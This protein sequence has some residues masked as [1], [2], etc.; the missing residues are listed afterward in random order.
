MRSTRPIDPPHEPHGRASVNQGVAITALSFP[1]PFPPRLFLFRNG[2][3][4]LAF[5]GWCH[6]VAAVDWVGVWGVWSGPD[7]VWMG[8]G[9]FA[10]ALLWG[11]SLLVVG[12]QSSS[13]VHHCW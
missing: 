5:V 4:T 3:L 13:T 1:P 8:C 9:V 2:D 11:G 6:R 7:L 10:A 12:H